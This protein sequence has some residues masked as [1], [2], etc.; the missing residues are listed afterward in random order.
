MKS[1]DTH[2]KRASRNTMKVIPQLLGNVQI[3]KCTDSLLSR[4]PLYLSY[5]DTE[6]PNNFVYEEVFY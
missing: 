6:Y 2:I 5:S 3:R 4:K 1:L